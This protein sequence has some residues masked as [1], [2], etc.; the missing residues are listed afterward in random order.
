MTSQRIL[1]TREIH[2]DLLARL[3]QHFEVEANQE[4]AIWGA[5]ELL[6]RLQ[7]KAG[8]FMTG[9]ERVDAALARVD[10]NYAEALLALRDEA[11]ARTGGVHVGTVHSS[12][13]KEFDRVAIVGLEEGSLP[14]S[15]AD[16]AEEARV[17][18]VAVTRAR[19]R[20][21]LT[22]CQVRPENRGPKLPPGPSTTRK[23]SRFIDRIVAGVGAGVA[24]R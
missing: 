16:E 7:D 8:A 18:F 17:L 22:W 24:S 13:G 15:G 14:L 19:T 10:G 12:K 4:D 23:R 21:L 11:P 3:Q 9:I 20:L 6:Q 1:V 2:A 5:D